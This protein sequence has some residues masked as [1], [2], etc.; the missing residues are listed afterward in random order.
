VVYCTGLEIRRVGNDTESSNLS[1]S[2]RTTDHN[3]SH[4][5][6]LPRP[7]LCE[8]LTSPQASATPRTGVGLVYVL[9]QIAKV[10]ELTEIER[11]LIR[12][13]EQANG[14]LPNPH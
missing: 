10:L 14:K 1:P 11:R 13:E 3:R 4:R 8:P 9:A 12:L 5:R 2:A 7:L 6:N